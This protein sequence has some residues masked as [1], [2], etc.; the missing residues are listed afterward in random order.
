M[1]LKKIVLMAGL[2]FCPLLAGA[3]APPSA[4]PEPRVVLETSLGR[5]E[6]E[7]FESAAPISAA[8]FLRYVDE[9]F[10]DGL[11]FHRVIANFMVQGGGFEPG[12]QTRATTHKAILNEADNGLKNSRGTLAMARTENIYSGNAQFYLNLKD[13]PTLDHKGK[14]SESFGYAVFGKV[15]SGMEVVERIGATPTGT[16]KGTPDVPTTEVVIK[17]A[18]RVEEAGSKDASP[19]PAP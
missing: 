17:R 18:Y 4:T 2:L 3:E 5:I 13:N 6:L 1:M 14:S 9:K 15:V 11:I 16:V 8:H 7:L 12:L 10:Y 19:A